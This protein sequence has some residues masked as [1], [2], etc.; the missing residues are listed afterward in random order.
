[1]TTELYSGKKSQDVLDYL[2]K[3]RSMKVKMMRAPAPDAQELDIILKAASRVPDHGKMFP[4]YFMVFEGDARKQVGEAL[5]QAWLT[6]EPEAAPAKLELEAERF[7]RAPMV[8]GVISRMRKGKNPQ[9]EQ[10]LS[11]GAACQNLGLAANALGYATNWLTEWY[12]YNDTFRTAIGL[13]ERDHVAGFIYIGTPEG[14]MEERDRPDLSKIVTHWSPDAA[15]NKGDEYDK[16][17]FDFPPEK[18]KFW[19]K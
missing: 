19:G 9:W 12:T 15:L 13:D 5:K 6:E 14:E 4:W 10:M 18:V 17:G 8:I 1:M 11:A 16:D 2:L 3:R 7:T